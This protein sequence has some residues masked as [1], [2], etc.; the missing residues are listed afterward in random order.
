MGQIQTPTASSGSEHT[1]RAWLT[2]IGAFFTFFCSVGFINAFGV[3]QDYYQSHQLSSY[4]SFDISWIGSFSTFAL[5]SGAP[6]AGVLVD[7]V[8]PTVLLIFGGLAMLVAVF[9]TSLCQQYYQFFLAQAVL[10]GASMSCLFCP[11]IATVSRYFHKNKGLAMG[12][13]VGGSSAGGVVWP[14]VLNELLNKDGVTFGWTIR[15]V[16][17]I[18]L[19]L[20]VLA[21]LTVTPPAKK[22]DD[23]HHHHMLTDEEE[24]NKR[25][26]VDGTHEVL[27]EEASAHKQGLVSLLKNTTFM[28]LC[29]GLS[30]SYL[31]MFSPFFYATSYAQSLGHST[32]FAFY[33]VS[34]INAASLFGRILPGILADRYG[35]FN[36]CG[37][38]AL[39][40]GATALCWT[41]AKSSGGLVVWCLAYGLTSGAI[42]SLQSACAA[43][44]APHELHGTAV[45]LLMGSVAL[46]ALFG[47][48]ISGQLVESYGYLALSIYAGASLVVGGILIFMAR[49]KMERRVFARQ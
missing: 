31:G 23:G 5:F 7:R 13:T 35:H 33:L 22:A 4:S 49:F 3:F 6:I 26:E 47:T 19:P 18:M 34:I 37:T 2:V 42:M 1:F 43:H 8:G 44:L 48:P 16:G 32:S 39:L 25:H 11:A 36:L 15:I 14:I 29:S 45:G 46:T 27:Q 28:V 9:M 38:A 24:R 20:L 12:V 30:I 17:F 10:L 40:S 21:V 41:A